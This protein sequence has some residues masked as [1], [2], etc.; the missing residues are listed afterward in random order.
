MA[1]LRNVIMNIDTR[2]VNVTLLFQE[3]IFSFGMIKISDLNTLMVTVL[4]GTPSITQFPGLIAVVHPE[5]QISIIIEGKRIVISNGEAKPFDARKI[6][7]FL[8]IVV[9]TF[10][11]FSS[12]PIDAY[13]FNYLY[14]NTTEIA[15]H[16]ASL[17]HSLVDTAPLGI[18]AAGLVGIGVNIAFKEE[19]KRIQLQ[20]SPAYS[21][22]TDEISGIE[23]TCNIH[24]P[25][26]V[27]PPFD[28]L[29]KDFKK[30]HAEMLEKVR[31][32][33]LPKGNIV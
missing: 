20:I 10:D 33:Q 32:A 2:P 30:Y 21:V 1:Q 17:L 13:G 26:A 12:K 31:T 15:E 27:L 11:I 23:S 14:T 6:D 18:Q 19:A 8:K 28:E 29:S 4:E 22:S 25:S 16:K 3:E 24:I 7:E 9:K 5:T